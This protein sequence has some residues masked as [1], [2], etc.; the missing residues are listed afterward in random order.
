MR[1]A[2]NLIAR[3][4]A[5]YDGIVARVDPAVPGAATFE[6][7]MGPQLAD[8]GQFALE[9]RILCFYQSVSTDPALRNVSSQVEQL[10]DEF[11]IEM[12]MRQDLFERV[13]AVVAD[14]EAVAKLDGEDQRVLQKE[15]RE[16]LRNGLGLQGEERERFK[17]IKRRLS[18]IQNAFQ[19]NLTEENGGLWFTREEMDGVPD[20]VIDGLKVGT[21]EDG[22]NE[23]K[24][25]VTFKYPDLFPT[26]KYATNSETRRKLMVE[27]ERKMPANVP[28]FKE[29]IVLRDEAARL[30]GYPNHAAF[31]VETKMAKTAENVDKF[32]GNLRE[33][34]I[35]GG[36][37]ELEKL[38]ALKAA[39]L[40]ERGLENDGHY[41]LW[42]NRYY[43]RLM[44]EK[45]YQVDHQLIAEY[46]P[47]ETTI[48]GMLE[49]FEHL[50]WLN[51]VEL[52]SKEDRDAVA[53]NGQ[54]SDIVWHEDVQFFSVW[55][56]ESEG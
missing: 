7:V 42:D 27:N 35:V 54:G 30:L 40:K 37:A 55:N 32:L 11:S 44:V 18:A 5:M 10:L 45:D 21:K 43:D 34:L 52:K 53:E 50:F 8:E 16:F 3:S 14:K 2:K 25:F 26:L 33:R 31:K 20:D 17:E 9:A 48:R 56:D 4:G 47:L 46:F 19:K 23:G 28:L 36:K 41:Y 6:S 38:K 22:E 51:F 13:K 39:D 12:G 1:D 49:I 29:A 24:L 15:Y